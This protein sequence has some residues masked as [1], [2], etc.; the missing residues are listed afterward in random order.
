[1]GRSLTFRVTSVD[2]DRESE[3]FTVPFI[4]RSQIERQPS[5]LRAR[6]I[7]GNVE[8]SWQGVGRLGGGGRVGMGAQFDGFRVTINGAAQVTQNRAISVP[9]TGGAFTI[10]VQQINRIT[11]LGPSLTVVA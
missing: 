7:G 10:S 4:G 11:G 3:V 9:D 1:L 6:R 5:Y 8:I 2:A